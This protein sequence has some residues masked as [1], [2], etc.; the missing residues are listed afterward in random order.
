MSA[1]IRMSTKDETHVVL[2]VSLQSVPTALRRPFAADRSS[3]QKL[4]LAR[5]HCMSIGSILV[6]LQF[7]TT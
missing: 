5:A 3:S 7:H 6:H 2:F 1:W 4:G